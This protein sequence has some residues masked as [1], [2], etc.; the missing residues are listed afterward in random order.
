M[1]ALGAAGALRLSGG[2]IAVLGL[3]AGGCLALRARGGRTP[4]RQPATA[5]EDRAPE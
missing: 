1:A 4:R 3:T 2:A 5:L